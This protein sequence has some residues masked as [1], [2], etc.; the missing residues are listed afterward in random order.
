MMHHL[1]NACTD[2]G[3]ETIV[4]PPPTAGDV[5]LEQ[6]YTVI[7]GTRDSWV[8]K[9]Y[10]HRTRQQQHRVRTL[11]E[12]LLDSY[13]V[14]AVLLGSALY[15]PRA[16]R[17][18]YT[19][20]QSKRTPLA[21]FA[22]G[23]DVRCSLV[24]RKA[25]KE[26]GGA[27]LGL[28]G[29]ARSPYQESKWSLRDADVI[30]ANSEYTARL[31]EQVCGRDATVTGCGLADSDYKRE[32]QLT[33]CFDRSSKQR[34]R[35]SLGLPDKPTVSFV[36]RLVPHKNVRLLLKALVGLAD[37]QVV[38]VGD[39]PDKANLKELA[40]SLGLSSRIHWMGQQIEET[41][42]KCLRASDVFC[43]PTEEARNGWVEGFGIVLL[44]AAAAGTPVIAARAGG[45]TDVVADQKTGLLC[46]PTDPNTLY[47][48]IRVLVSNDALAA[49]CVA[50]ARLQIKRRFNW[51][52]VA[53][54]IVDTISRVLPDVFSTCCPS[55]K[56]KESTA[57]F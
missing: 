22:H 25:Y 5:A 1:A 44:E 15:D 37:A 39:G 26:F 21:V 32:M 14:D 47:E 4:G 41:K 2:Y 12:D 31:V 16:W 3:I 27:I 51:S 10:W 38:I 49:S 18:V 23:G 33:P 56:A 17:G 24:R 8:R 46:H 28:A 55:L 20:C 13:S 45:M 43:L 9:A 30:F 34:W 7:A 52:A 53:K 48:A 36:G 6:R 19:A 50:E 11:T 42:W 35:Q 54:T 29:I 40:D 57:T